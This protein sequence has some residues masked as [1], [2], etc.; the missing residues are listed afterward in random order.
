MQHLK[1]QLPKCNTDLNLDF[2]SSFGIAIRN[3][4]EAVYGRGSFNFQPCKIRLSLSGAVSWL[5]C[6]AH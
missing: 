3:R 4:I 1:R 5:G 2:T 6:F